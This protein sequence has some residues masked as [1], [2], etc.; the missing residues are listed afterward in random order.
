MFMEKNATISYLKKKS[1][2][3]ILANTK[4]FFYTYKDVMRELKLV[5]FIMKKFNVAKM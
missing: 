1:S 4:Q 2:T 5:I 3:F